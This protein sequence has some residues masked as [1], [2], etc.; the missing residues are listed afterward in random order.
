MNKNPYQILGVERTAGADDIKRAYRRLAS[1][2]HPDRGGDTAKFQEIEQAYRILTN[3]QQR[4]QL[5]NPNPFN[6]AGSNF[7][8]GAGFNFETIFDVFGARF[9]QAPHQHRPQQ[10]RLSLWIQLQDVAE[11]GKKTI[12]VGTQQG[13]MTVE[14]EIPPGINDGDTVQYAK[15]GPQ[16]MDLVITFRI[17][18]N[19]R[20]IRQGANLTTEYVLDI[21]DLILGADVTVRDLQNTALSLN[22]PPRTQ[23]GTTFR[24]RERGLKQ[25]SGN[26]GDLFIR[27]QARLPD[28][29]PESVIQ[30][31][32]QTRPQ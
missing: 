1:Q 21:W 14:I 18:P 9:T 23:P 28:N 4:A 19:P 13:N 17:H 25:R 3:P 24:L 2:H 10:A 8:P 16:G 15:I 31:I 7:N 26:A 30:A 27:V 5:D 32:A 29:I 6:G 22:I 12:G 11:G 20:W